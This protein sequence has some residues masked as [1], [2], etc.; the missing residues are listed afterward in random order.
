MTNTRDQASPS[1]RCARRAWWDL[2]QTIPRIEGPLDPKDPFKIPWTSGYRPAQWRD[3]PK[4]QGR[5]VDLIIMD[6]IGI[7]SYDAK[8]PDGT[9]IEYKTYSLAERRKAESKLFSCDF[10]E[11]EKR[12][13]A[14]QDQQAQKEF[15]EAIHRAGRTI[16]S[17][18]RLENFRRQIP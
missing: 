15:T 10:L 18:Q 16:E 2:Y 17:R 14:Y 6:D 7:P 11:V 9:I 13:L 12:I 5:H 8:L 4:F 3:R 1:G